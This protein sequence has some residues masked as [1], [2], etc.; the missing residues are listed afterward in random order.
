MVSV[1]SRKSTAVT[2]IGPASW[3][4]ANPRPSTHMLRCT[5]QTQTCLMPRATSTLC[6]S[7]PS[8][9][10]TSTSWRMVIAGDWRLHMGLSTFAHGCAREISN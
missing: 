8:S 6:S 9:V 10:I 7:C 3:R 1:R 4:M 2:P 5:P